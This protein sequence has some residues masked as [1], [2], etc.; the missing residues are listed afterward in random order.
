MKNKKIIILTAFSVLL[1]A[2]LIIYYY[3]KS[4]TITPIEFKDSA[5]MESYII[6]RKEKF[7]NVNYSIGILEDQTQSKEMRYGAESALC[8]IE[9]QNTE[10][11]NSLL[12][13]FSNKEEKE[14]NLRYAIAVCFRDNKEL[15]AVD[16]LIYALK[17]NDKM[18]R[19]KAAQ[20]L[21]ELKIQKAVAPLEN[22]L[23]N[24]SD[25]TVRTNA[26]RSLEMITGNS[27]K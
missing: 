23:K 15:R 17:D 10:A 19:F 9:T 14:P 16:A 2:G 12:T 26:A 24:D 22:M 6:K 7:K 4:N 8:E 1:G 13:V 21:G 25:K 18:M 3:L 11:F 20:V 27:Y 5:D